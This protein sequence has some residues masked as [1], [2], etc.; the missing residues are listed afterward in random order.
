MILRSR[1]TPCSPEICTGLTG[2]LAD[3]KIT[4]SKFFVQSAE[5]TRFANTSSRSPDKH[6]GIPL[7]G[8]CSLSNRSLRATPSP[9]RTATRAPSSARDALPPHNGYTVCFLL[10][11]AH[12]RQ[13][14]LR[15]QTPPEVWE[16]NHLQSHST[17]TQCRNCPPTEYR[18]TQSAC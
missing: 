12:S 17:T 13:T 11:T 9:S 6:L 1:R 16:E 14:Q 10:A 15:A 3:K 4:G 8:V 2:H 18:Q 5:T 7:P